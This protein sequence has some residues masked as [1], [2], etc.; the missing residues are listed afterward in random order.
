MLAGVRK[1]DK[2]IQWDLLFAS[3]YVTISVAK[4][5]TLFFENKI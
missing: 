4:I 2:I 1:I 3:I 5:R